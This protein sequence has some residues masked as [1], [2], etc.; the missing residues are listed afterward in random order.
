MKTTEMLLHQSYVHVGGT[1]ETGGCSQAPCRRWTQ[2]QTIMA[3]MHMDSW[4]ER[5]PKAEELVK[6]RHR[7]KSQLCAGTGKQA[8]LAEVKEKKKLKT[9]MGCERESQRRLR[10]PRLASLDYSTE[11]FLPSHSRA[12]HLRIF[13]LKIILIT[14]FGSYETVSLTY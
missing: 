1:Q 13:L 2:G 11:V 12:P 9:D 14:K 4:G 5:H 7:S 8:G 6:Q 3:V 10:N